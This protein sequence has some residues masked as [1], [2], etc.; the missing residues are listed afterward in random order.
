MFLCAVLCLLTAAV[1]DELAVRLIRRGKLRSLAH[2]WQMHFA[3]GDR[4]RLALRV[5]SQLPVP[6]AADVRVRD[7]IFRTENNQHQ[8]LF[9]ID[10]TVGVVRGKVGR[11]RVAGFQE[12]VTRGGQVHITPPALTLA[13]QNLH[14]ADA[15]AHVRDALSKLL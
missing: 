8:Y 6:G 11:S 1:I 13:P 14:L 5:A 2:Q 10:Y 12:P 9:T 3:P 7:L 15:Y 4:L